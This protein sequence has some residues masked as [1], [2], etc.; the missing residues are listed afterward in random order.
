MDGSGGEAHVEEVVVKEV[1]GGL[2]AAEDQGTT[3]LVK[4]HEIVEGGLALIVGVRLDDQ[5][6]DVLVRLTGTADTDAEVVLGHELPSQGASILWKGC[7]EE[8]VDVVGILIGI[9]GCESAG[10]SS[11]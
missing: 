5:L 4:R 2:G 3:R 7:R 1:D 9:C 11:K 6:I 10:K 8:H